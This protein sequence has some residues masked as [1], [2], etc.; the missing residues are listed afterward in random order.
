MKAW[1]QTPI[2]Q[3]NPKNKTKPSRTSSRPSGAASNPGLTRVDCGWT[4]KGW[5]AGDGSRGEDRL[6]RAWEPLWGIRLWLWVL[7][8]GLHCLSLSRQA[9]LYA[10]AP[11]GT[12][13]CASRPLSFSGGWVD[14]VVGSVDQVGGSMECWGVKLSGRE[15]NSRWPWRFCPVWLRGTMWPTAKLLVW[16]HRCWRRVGGRAVQGILS[17]V[18][19]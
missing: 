11:G 4:E 14:Q 13:A 10:A 2:T 1:V 16:W 15:R 8:R 6:Q 18:M 9:A 5:G 19:S 12:Q 7:S 3:K 17:F